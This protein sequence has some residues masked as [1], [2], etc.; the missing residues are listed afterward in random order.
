[1]VNLLHF[2]AKAWIPRSLILPQPQAS[3]VLKSGSIDEM[4]YNV[5]S[6]TVGQLAIT[7]VVNLVQ[8]VTISFNEL[9]RI[10]LQPRISRLCR[11][12]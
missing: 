2:F 12:F 10:C 8:L 5:E 7:N 4:V 9:S 1:M 6:V 11:F 3:S